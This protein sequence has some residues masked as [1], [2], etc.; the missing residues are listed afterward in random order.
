MFCAYYVLQQQLKKVTIGNNVFKAQFGS[1]TFMA[2]RAQ[3]GKL[4]ISFAQRNKWNKDWSRYWFYVK[5]SSLNTKDKHGNK[6]ICYPLASTMEEMRP[7]M[8][9]TTK[10]DAA[11][12]AY[13]VAFAT[14]CHYFRGRD[15]MEEMVAANFCPIGKEHR[16]KMTLKRLMLLVFGETEGVL[17]LHFG[18]K[19]DKGKTDAEIITQI[20]ATMTKILDDIFERKYL[21]WRAIGGTMPRLN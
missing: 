3:K 1:C 2:K 6:D 15:L 5:T 19:R 16:P 8:R 11:W 21:A 10:I 14:T 17:S 12:E 13:D 20:E 4:E 7:S 9:L 18:L